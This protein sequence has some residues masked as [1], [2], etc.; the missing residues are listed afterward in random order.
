MNGWFYDLANS[1]T[2]R[3]LLSP[4]RRELLSSLQ[5]AIIDVGAG[6]GANF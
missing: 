2:E 4:L 5:G 1:L 6:T 3:Y